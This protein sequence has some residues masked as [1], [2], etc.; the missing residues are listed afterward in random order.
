MDLDAYLDRIG[1]GGPTAPSLANVT[2]LLAAHMAAVPFENLDVLLGRPPRLDLDGLTDK[3]VRRRRGGYCFE[4][5]TLLGAVLER[6]GYR[7]DYH[8]ARVIMLSPPALAPRSHMFL[9]VRFAEG[10]F[11][12]DPGFGGLAPRLPV[13][14][15]GGPVSIEQERH[16]MVPAGGLRALHARVGDRECDAWITTLEH[17]YP[18][19]YEMGNHFTATHPSSAFTSR[20]MLR[21]LTPRGRVNV[22]NRDVTIVTDGVAE[23]RTLETRADLRA[24]LVE[25]FGFDLPEVETMRVS[26]VP[27]WAM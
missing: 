2:A 26:S 20:L 18:V 10:A 8:M 24:L 3:L 13:P 21:A 11:V 16:E 9:V 7:P 19:D 5:G 22:M 23:K 12:L 4:H 6:L 27:E 14:L 25:Y 1:F 17:H 15:D